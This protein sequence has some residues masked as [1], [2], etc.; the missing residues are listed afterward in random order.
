M[1][2]GPIRAYLL[3]RLLRP[4]SGPPGDDDPLFSSG[5]IDSFGVLELIAFL[6][7]RHG[8]VIDTTK[9]HILDFDTLRKIAAVV[10]KEQRA[11]GTPR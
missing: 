4:G 1:D 2:T 8:I 10:E 9:H 3:E 5:R 7:E 11:G 6:E